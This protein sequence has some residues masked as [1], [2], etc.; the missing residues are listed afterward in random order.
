L[1]CSQGAQNAPAIV[2]PALT[3]S[4]LVDVVPV[5]VQS[6]TMPPMGAQAPSAV[7]PPNGKADNVQKAVEEHRNGP[8][9]P[10]GDPPVQAG[11]SNLAGVSTVSFTTDGK[12]E[13]TTIHPDVVTETI[14]LTAQSATPQQS[15]PGLVASPSQRAELD[16]TVSTTDR[17][18][19]VDQV[20]P[21]LVGVLKATDG[22]QSVTV[23]LQPAELGQVTIRVDRTSEG[24]AHISITADRPET[25]QLLQRDE[26]RLQQTLDQA[27][28]PSSGRSVTF[29]T[30]PPD[31][32]SASA[33]RPD[34]MEAGSGGSG[35][36]QS[37]GAWRENSDG[38]QSPGRGPPSD[39]R[40]ARER[41]YRAGLDITA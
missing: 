4:P 19:P 31:Q 12:L 35:Q 2:T 7:T 16:Q 15:A 14:A 24:M 32:L 30:T 10:R 36:G 23:R 39:E 1:N 33:S 34:T 41:W 20:A 25:L 27:G 29:Q 18:A 3:P 40:H 17:A 6:G 37:G 22:T 9:T 28:V 26:P 8:A 21:A 13:R 11:Q 38:Q 5:S